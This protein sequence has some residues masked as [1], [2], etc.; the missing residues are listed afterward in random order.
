M[1][2]MTEMVQNSQ[3]WAKAP[4]VMSERDGDK[5]MNQRIDSKCLRAGVINIE[6]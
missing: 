1:T 6:Q 2:F 4:R 5:I 3:G